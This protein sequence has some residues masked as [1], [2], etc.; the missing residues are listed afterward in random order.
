M[1]HLC[2]RLGWCPWDYLRPILLSLVRQGFPQKGLTKVTLCGIITLWCRGLLLY[3]KER[4]M[5][6]HYACNLMVT[7][8]IAQAKSEENRKKFIRAYL[9][10]PKVPLQ[11][12]RS[13]FFKLPKG[14]L[15]STYFSG[16]GKV[17]RYSDKKQQRVVLKDLSLYDDFYID[18]HETFDPRNL[19][20]DSLFNLHYYLKNNGSEERIRKEQRR[21]DLANFLVDLAICRGVSTF[22]HDW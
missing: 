5:E 17:E 22:V 8:A 10:N 9:M 18:R 6:S 11:A 19:L 16:H 20:R 21:V 12:A 2:E 1:V 15:G 14:Y 4:H 3:L 7:D 13:I